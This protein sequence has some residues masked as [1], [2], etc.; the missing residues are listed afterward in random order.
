ME[1]TATA[2]LI[3]SAF[4]A[5][6]IWLQI[7]LSK[8]ENKWAGLILP[9]VALCLS[10]IAVLGIGAFTTTSLAVRVED[11]NG[12]VVQE[13]VLSATSA[14]ISPIH[15]TPA[16]ILTVV[17]VFL[18]SNIPTLAFLAIYFACREKQRQR[19]ALEKMQAQDLA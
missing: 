17:G 16:L 1:R 2:L 14:R 8:K 5:G 19:K 7:F 3:L 18:V 6:I 9:A 4:C 11:E 12:A 13:E 10:F 15:D